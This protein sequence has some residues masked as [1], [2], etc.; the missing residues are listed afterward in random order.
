MELAKE[1][2]IWMTSFHA[3][4]QLLQGRNPTIEVYVDA[5]P[6]AEAFVVSY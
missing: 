6:A 2:D 4:D 1:L 5:P 3:L